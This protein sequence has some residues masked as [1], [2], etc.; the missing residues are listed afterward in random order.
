MTNQLESKLTEILTSAQG[1]GTDIYAVVQREAPELAREVV[2]NAVVNNATDLILGAAG[3]LAC[4]GILIFTWRRL[5]SAKDYED[6]MGY[7]VIFI[8]TAVII[9]PC[10]G[11]TINSAGDLA[12][13]YYAPRVVFI[14]EAARIVKGK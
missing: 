7:L 12:R 14:Q 9:I 6:T 5:R 11:G 4:L 2:V 13:C 3:S 8:V 10:I 1:V